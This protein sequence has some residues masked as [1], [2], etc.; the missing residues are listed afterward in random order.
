MLQEVYV[1]VMVRR[2]KTLLNAD[3]KRRLGMGYSVI[4]GWN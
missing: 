1:F 2:N 3:G 4:I